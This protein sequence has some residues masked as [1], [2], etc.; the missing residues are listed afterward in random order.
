MTRSLSHHALGA[1]HSRS[2][3]AQ[4]RLR[5][6]GL[7]GRRLRPEGVWEDALPGSKWLPRAPLSANALGSPAAATAREGGELREGAGGAGGREARRWGGGSEGEGARALRS[8]ARSL[9]AGGGTGRPCVGAH[10][11]SLPSRPRSLGGE[12]L[13]SAEA[14]GS[15]VG[16]CALKDASSRSRAAGG[17]WQLRLGQRRHLPESRGEDDQSQGAL[18]FLLDLLLGQH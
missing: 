12:R 3:I 14:S 8:P 11:R 5:L 18:L 16:V 10:G 1:F 17:G 13:A 2:S 7:P 6:S 4:L 9:P 15:A